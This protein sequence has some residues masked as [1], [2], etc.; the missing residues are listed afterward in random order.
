H[1]RK[2]KDRSS[3]ANQ[4]DRRTNPNEYVLAPV[5]RALPQPNRSLQRTQTHKRLTVHV[6]ATPT[7]YPPTN[8]RKPM[9]SDLEFDQPIAERTLNS[10]IG[11]IVVKLGPTR[12]DQAGMK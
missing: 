12:T 5:R 1:Q 10:N 6:H 2:H 9:N 3:R 8:K 11:K 7:A 4:T